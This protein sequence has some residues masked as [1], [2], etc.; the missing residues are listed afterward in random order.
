MVILKYRFESPACLQLGKWIVFQFS[1]IHLLLQ[2]TFLV[3]MFLYYPNVLLLLF[4]LFVLIRTLLKE[5][6]TVFPDLLDL[7]LSVLKEGLSGSVAIV[8]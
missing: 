3:K 1:K 7:S 4:C 5:P 6:T 2:C 8:L